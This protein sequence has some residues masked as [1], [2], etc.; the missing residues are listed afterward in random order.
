MGIIRPISSA[1]FDILCLFVNLRIINGLS[2]PR[3]LCLLPP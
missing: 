3:L 2:E 1:A